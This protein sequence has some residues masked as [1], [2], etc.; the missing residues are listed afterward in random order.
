M[1]KDTVCTSY[2]TGRLVLERKLGVD[3][4]LLVPLVFEGRD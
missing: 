3:I 4:S 1:I 2:L